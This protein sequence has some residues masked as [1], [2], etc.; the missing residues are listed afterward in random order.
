MTLPEHLARALSCRHP[1]Q[2]FEGQELPC[3][4]RG[5]PRGWDGPELKIGIMFK[6]AE[7]QS[8]AE[9]DPMSI[10]GHFIFLERVP[11]TRE[12]HIEWGRRS[13]PEGMFYDR[14]VIVP[15]GRN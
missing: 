4:V 11:I 5:C 10:A 13:Y 15:A 7:P 1:R 6:R 12:P 9:E 14:N 3:A 2:T 8:Y